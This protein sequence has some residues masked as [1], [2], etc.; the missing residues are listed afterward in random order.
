MN[1]DH[2]T[3]T[4]TTEKSKQASDTITTAQQGDNIDDQEALVL[5]QF[6]DLD[7]AQY[8][9]HFSNKFKTINID[10]SSPIIQIGT[11]FY[12]GEYTNNIGTYLFF[13]ETNQHK[14]NAANSDT[15]AA[16][17]S[18]DH[19]SNT[20]NTTTTN[21]NNN[22]SSIASNSISEESDS[23]KAASNNSSAYYGKSFKKLIL[24]RLFIEEKKKT[25]S[26]NTH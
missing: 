25:A 26:D 17:S 11:R 14:D 13:E 24:T 4:K 12:T 7:D 8:C 16:T 2:Q 20:N 5:L 1:I 6:T 22:K 21:N 23:D 18:T 15:K 10:Q 9:Q 19:H 3:K